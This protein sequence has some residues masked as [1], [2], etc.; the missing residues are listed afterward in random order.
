MNGQRTVNLGLAKE[1]HGFHINTSDA[2]VPRIFASFASEN[3]RG[4]RPKSS[5]T[6]CTHR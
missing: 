3:P 1:I 2:V 4:E 5:A 6:A